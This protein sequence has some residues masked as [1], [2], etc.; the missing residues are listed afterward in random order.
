MYEN[1]YVPPILTVDC[2]IFQLIDNNLSVLLIERKNAPF[3]G[4]WA[5]PGGYNA[6][7]ETTLEAMKRVLKAKGGIASGDLTLVEQL[8]TFDTVARDPRGHAVSV[9][10]M[11]LGRDL[12][13]AISDTSQNPQ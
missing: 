12:A 9:A 6:A 1:G 8:Y 4:R 2:I 10:Y 3:K 13:P 7:G 11:G 5:L